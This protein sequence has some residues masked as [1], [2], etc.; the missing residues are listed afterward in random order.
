MMTEWLRLLGMIFY[1]PF[2]GMREVR[3]RGALLPAIVCAYLSQVAYVF[4][5]QWLAGD[6]SFLVRPTALAGSLF[7]AAASL[8]PIALV[9]VPLLALIANIFERKGSFGVVVRQEYASFASV[10]FYVLVGTNLATIL[11]ALFFH[12]SGIQAASL[13]NMSKQ[14]LQTIEMWRSMGP[15]AEAL[16]RM[17]KGSKRS[18]RHVRGHLFVPKFMLFAFGIRSGRPRGPSRPGVARGC[19]CGVGRR[20]AGM[21]LGP[22][23]HGL[24]PYRTRVTVSLSML[25]FLLPGLL[26][27]SRRHQRAGAAFKQNLKRPPSTRVIHQHITILA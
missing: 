3:D 15:S 24:F 19:Y 14:I 21:L 9:L 8:L 13:A 6:R 10:M 23:W 25:F 26:H 7:Q 12:F 16:A 18:D 1:A 2:R 27:R 17:E 20:L 11:I 22:I 4:A 5:I